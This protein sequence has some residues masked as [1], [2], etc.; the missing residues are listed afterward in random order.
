[1][2]KDVESWADWIESQAFGNFT[3]YIGVSGLE[4]LYVQPSGAS[5]FQK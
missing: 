1:M 4:I 5:G 3:Y 2:G